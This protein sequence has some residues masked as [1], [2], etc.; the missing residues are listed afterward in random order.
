LFLLKYL[1]V[2]VN[3]YNPY[4][5][6]ATSVHTIDCP[7]FTGAQAPT[8]SWP[9]VP[10]KLFPVKFTGVFVVI[11]TEF[12]AVVKFIPVTFTGVFN[13]TVSFPR[14]NVNVWPVITAATAISIETLF[15]VVVNCWPVTLASGPGSTIPKADVSDWPVKETLAVPVTVSSPRDNVNDWPVSATDPSIEKD[16]EFKDVLNNCPVTFTGVI[17]LTVTVPWDKLRPILSPQAP[18]P[19]LLAPHVVG[20][21]GA[22]TGTSIPGNALTLFKVKF[23]KLVVR[24]KFAVPIVETEFKDVDKLIPVS[25]TDPLI[26]RDTEFKLDVNDCPVT[27]TIGLIEFSP[28]T[29]SPQTYAPQPLVTGSWSPQSPSL[30]LNCPHL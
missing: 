28:Q 11:V 2:F 29:D 15:N 30:Q 20:V 25:A 21:P 7:V 3:Q 26:E 16:T 4:I 6:A 18:L 14:L 23:A 10:V 24:V 22:V 1:S 12:K 5:Y 17:K 27:E 19:Q 8:Y 13:S 9:V